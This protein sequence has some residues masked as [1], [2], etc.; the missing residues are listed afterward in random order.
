MNARQARFVEEY[1]V[2][3]NATQAAIRAGY[4]EKTAYSQ[5]SRL[6]KNAEIQARVRARTD[7]INSRLIAKQ[8]EVR[9]MLTRMLRGEEHETV[10]SEG[11]KVVVPVGA[12]DRIRAA[13]LLGKTYGMFTENVVAEVELPRI[14]ANPDGS[15]ELADDGA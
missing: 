13:E 10:V 4:S 3:M 6:L 1:L 11:C 15:V 2:D 8:T 7:E 12:R 5:G 9:Q 14:I